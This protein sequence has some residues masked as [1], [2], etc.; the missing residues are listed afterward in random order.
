M[1]HLAHVICVNNNTLFAIIYL[2]INCMYQ[3]C[4]IICH[5]HGIHYQWHLVWNDIIGILI[6]QMNILYLC[7]C[8]AGHKDAGNTKI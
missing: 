5:I 7:G 1:L 6:V 3:K 8:L 4:Y 2:I